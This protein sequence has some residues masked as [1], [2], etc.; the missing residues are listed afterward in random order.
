MIGR[1][2]VAA[3]VA[4]CCAC[5]DTS[6]A[7]FAPSRTVPPA[8]GGV[9]SAGSLSLTQS[10]EFGSDAWIYNPAEL[11]PGLIGKNNC[12]FAFPMTVVPNFHPQNEADP[13]RGSCWERHAGQEGGHDG[14][15]REQTLALHLPAATA[16]GGRPGD[17]A[18]IRVCRPGGRGQETPCGPTG[19]NGCAACDEKMTCH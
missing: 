3:L 16:C 18:G 8:P 14:L 13:L 2:A 5:G 10:P 11:P 15:S 17:L 12:T 9:S 6:I 7:P 19:P 1:I 4:F